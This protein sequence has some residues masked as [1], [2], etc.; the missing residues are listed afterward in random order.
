M[1]KFNQGILGG[2]SGKVGTVIGAFWKGR[3]VMRALPRY[4]HDANTPDQQKQRAKFKTVGKLVSIMSPLLAIGYKMFAVDE[5]AQNVFVRD[6]LANGFG[7]SG[8]IDYDRLRFAKG[9]FVNVAT[10]SATVGQNHTLNVAWDDNTGAGIGVTGSDPVF[11]MA[12]NPAKNEMVYDTENNIREDESATLTHP[13]GWAGDTV[14]IYVATKELKGPICS[15]SVKAA[16][17][18][19]A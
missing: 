4:F 18:T 2:F 17:V 13:S 1:G 9:S 16:T 19:A 6:T 14:H 11:V 8:A 15:N 3:N 7:A 5:T 12:L 10:P